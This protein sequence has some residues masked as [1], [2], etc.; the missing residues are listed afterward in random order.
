MRGPP[1]C[2]TVWTMPDSTPKLPSATTTKRCVLSTL[3]TLGHLFA[4]QG[5]IPPQLQAEAALCR[6]VPVYAAAGSCVIYHTEL[7]HC[8]WD[9][10]TAAPRRTMQVLPC[11]KPLH[12]RCDCPRISLTVAGGGAGV[13]LLHCAPN[14]G[15]RR[16]GGLGAVPGGAPNGLP[17]HG[18]RSVAGA[19]RASV[20]ILTAASFPHRSGWPTVRTRP[21]RRSSARARSPSGP[22]QLQVAR[23]RS[24]VSRRNMHWRNMHLPNSPRANLCDQKTPRHISCC[25]LHGRST[26]EPR[27]AEKVRQVARQRRTDIPAAAKESHVAMMPPAASEVCGHPAWRRSRCWV[28]AHFSQARP[29]VAEVRFL[30]PGFF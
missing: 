17:M 16:R 23:Q 8:R 20:M 1:L 13:L 29:L 27:D 2:L 10:T 14:D 25:R 19:S 11:A 18:R 7:F 22:S 21:R 15:Q 12:A 28:T 3:C 26:A 30:P 4:P 6:Q 24:Y 9:G 5:R